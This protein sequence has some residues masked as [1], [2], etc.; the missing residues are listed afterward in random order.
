M[1]IEHIEKLLAFD[2]Y[3]DILNALPLLTYLDLDRLITS[4]E[5]LCFFTNLYNFLIIISHIELIRTP[6]TQ[7]TTSNI[8]RNE[9]E[10]LLFILTTRIDVGQ[11]KQIS[12]YDIRYYLLKQNI[13]SDGLKFDLD[14]TGPFYRY[15]PTIS[16]NQHIKIGLLLNDCT[17]SSSPFVILTPELFNEQLQRSTRDFIDKCD[18]IKT[19]Q[20]D[21]SVQIFL[22][23]LLF[24]QFDHNN[25]DMI[26][27]IGEYS[28]NNDVLCAING[29]R[30]LTEKSRIRTNQLKISFRTSHSNN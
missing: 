5:R 24:S 16:N 17:Y 21:N 8:F 4:E 6:I 12:L 9:L 22:P 15:A 27:F 11:L 23:N 2:D 20:D 25:D 14:P 29:K 10:R 13:L 7:I 1:A 3:D 18:L 30:R 19:N 28:S 26:K